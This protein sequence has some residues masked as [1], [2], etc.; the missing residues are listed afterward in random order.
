MEN[1]ATETLNHS[2][3]GSHLQQQRR[4][5]KENFILNIKL[6]KRPILCMGRNVFSTFGVVFIVYSNELEHLKTFLA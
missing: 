4:M 1:E 6:V 3:N 5:I 2:S